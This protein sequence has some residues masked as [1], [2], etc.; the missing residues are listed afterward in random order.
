MDDPLCGREDLMTPEELEEWTFEPSGSQIDT[1]PDSCRSFF[2]DL[3]G[4]PPPEAATRRAF[5]RRPPALGITDDVLK[6]L[7]EH[8][9]ILS[10]SPVQQ[11]QLSK[12]VRST[13]LRQLISCDGVDRC[14]LEGHLQIL[15][16]ERASGVPAPVPEWYKYSTVTMGPRKIGYDECSAPGCPRTEKYGSPKFAFCGGCKVAKYCGKDCQLADWKA[17]HKKVCKECAA[18]KEQIKMVGKAM[19]RLSD[20]SLTGNDGDIGCMFQNAPSNPDVRNRRRELRKEKKRPIG[21]PPPPGPD[22]S[23][24]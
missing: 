2:F 14:D 10:S 9:A 22:P 13:M 20:M 17:R 8:Y 5:E 24:F 15:E 4:R 11:R 6:G 3:D 12:L 23:F 19:Q 7:R 18:Q 16:K 1:I 21:Q